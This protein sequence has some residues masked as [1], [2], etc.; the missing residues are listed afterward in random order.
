MLLDI[1]SHHTLDGNPR[2]KHDRRKHENRLS[3]D[4]EGEE[5]EKDTKDTKDK[6]KGVETEQV[7]QLKNR[8]IYNIS[9]KWRGRLRLMRLDN[10]LLL[11]LRTIFMSGNVYE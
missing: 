6:E 5:E 1:M 2:P 8:I 10:G 9:V 3:T 7:E 11:G 4:A